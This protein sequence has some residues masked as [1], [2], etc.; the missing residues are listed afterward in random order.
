MADPAGEPI[1]L[2]EI[3]NDDDSKKYVFTVNPSAISILQDMKDKKVGVLVISGPQRSGKSFL[4]NRVLDQIKGFQLG[5]SVQP[6]TKGI[7][8]WSQPVKL[9][10]DHDFETIILDTEGLNSVQRDA[11]LDAKLFTISLLLSSTFLYNSIGHIDEQALDNLSLVVNLAKYIDTSSKEGNSSSNDFSTFFPYF[12]WV[13]RD[14]SLDLEGK[15]PIE[16]LNKSLRPVEGDNPDIKKKNEI[17]STISN[18]FKHRDCHCLI[19]PVSDEKQ[20]QRIE[21]VPLKNMKPLF[22][23]GLNLLK[24]KIKIDMRPKIVD[25]KVLTASM[26]LNLLF[27]YLEA[28]NNESAPNVHS[29]IERIIHAET[30]RICDNVLYEYYDQMDE[31]FGGDKIPVEEEQLR[32]KFKELSAEVIKKFEVQTREFAEVAQLIDLRNELLE[33][34]ETDFESRMQMNDELS[35]SLCKRIV[36]ELFNS[37]NLPAL[38]SMEDIRE[39]LILEYKQKFLVFYDNYKKFAKGTHKF[40]IFADF[41]PNFLFEFFDKYQMNVA[42]LHQEEVTSIKVALNQ[43]RSGEESLRNNLA[44]NYNMII[45]FQKERNEIR[46]ELEKNLRESNLKSYLV[47]EEIRSLQDTIYDLQ[48]KLEKKKEKIKELKRDR[49]D[50]EQ[51]LQKQKDENMI[52]K[53]SHDKLENKYI[54]LEQKSFSMSAN[55]SITGKPSTNPVLPDLMNN[56]ISQLSSIRESLAPINEKRSIGNERISTIQMEKDREVA[57]MKAEFDRRLNEGWERSKQLKE[58]YQRNNENLRRQYE[59]QAAENA[60]LKVQVID[61]TKTIENLQRKD[62][63]ID[64]LRRDLGKIAEEN[65]LKKNEYKVS[66]EVTELFKTKVENLELKL[67]DLEGKLGEQASEIARLKVQKQDV[68]WASKNA[69]AKA[70]K[71]KEKHYLRQAFENLDE[72]TADEIRQMLRDLGIKIDY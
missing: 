24:E 46:N 5:S 14:F 35:Q 71:P 28:L 6:C 41:A 1:P 29:T 33:K 45:E 22:L 40:E 30:R 58:E 39:S 20:L 3:Q 68:L 60:K 49:E 2:I 7:W 70:L 32:S 19:R 23:Q 55:P 44:E 63:A 72:E 10:E 48:E 42:R 25:G 62:Q 67:Q 9:S 27:E 21:E 56:L 4:A 31:E 38:L 59:S 52:L 15:T 12:I 26:F 11:T 18:Y 13:L 16:Y 66:V 36:N 17:R 47:Q 54:E 69:L 37:F 61:Y 8:M 51:L 57:Q 64:V 43:A 34:M 65:D 53:R 50:L